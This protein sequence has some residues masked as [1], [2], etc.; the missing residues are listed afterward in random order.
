MKSLKRA[1]YAAVSAAMVGAPTASYAVITVSPATNPP[2]F[3]SSVGGSIDAFSDQTINEFLPPDLVRSGG[4]IGYR[5]SSSLLAGPESGLFIAPAAGTVA[6][7]TVYYLDTLTFGA[8]GTNVYA[9]GASLFATN[10]L[11]E[12]T[13]GAMTVTITDTNALTFTRT[14]TGGSLSSF[15]G[16][17]STVP[18]ASV[19]AQITTANTNI[20]ATADN[21]VLSSRVQVA[22]VPESATWLMMIAGFG[23]IGWQRRSTRVLLLS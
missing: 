3:A 23:I 17:V 14:I 9:F 2:T 16:F 18:I 1:F 20:Y 15:I 8:F 21:V 10:I 13:A 5:V 6:V 11:G 4:P 19:V 12:A 7:S 22:A